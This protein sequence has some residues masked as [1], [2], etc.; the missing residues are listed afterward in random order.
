M[1][2]WF[3]LT[4]FQRT[5]V[6]CFTCV[7][8]HLAQS[9]KLLNYAKCSINFFQNCIITIVAETATNKLTYLHVCIKHCVKNLLKVIT[10]TLTTQV[11]ILKMSTKAACWC[12]RDAG[13]WDT[14][15]FE[16]GWGIGRVF[17]LLA[18]SGVYPW[19][20]NHFGEFLSVKMLLIAAIFIIFVQ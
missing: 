6:L 11:S 14:G 19:P 3:S 7:P 17:S 2:Q 8:S 9:T 12:A 13:K 18:W 1:V 16:E 15:C 20:Q 5:V 10:M 4:S